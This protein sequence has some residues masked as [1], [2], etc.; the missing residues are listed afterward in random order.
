MTKKNLKIAVTLVLVGT[1]AAAHAQGIRP[2]YVYPSTQAGGAQLGDSP[3]Y[4]NPYLGLAAGRDDNLFLTN[5]NKKT[6]TVYIASPGFKIDARSEASIL[7][8]TYQGQFGRYP[9]SQQDNYFDNVV[10]T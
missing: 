2:A 9:Q 7:Q 8:V 6:S 10:H 3:F 5:S 1:A 4:F